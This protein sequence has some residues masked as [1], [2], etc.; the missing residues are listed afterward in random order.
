M[1]RKMRDHKTINQ[2]S[3]PFMHLCIHAFN[4]SFIHPFNHAIFYTFLLFAFIAFPC[5]L[6]SQSLRGSVNDGVDFYK[7]KKFADAEIKFKKG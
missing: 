6:F 1:I 3:H 7:Q 5:S 4:H 2:Y